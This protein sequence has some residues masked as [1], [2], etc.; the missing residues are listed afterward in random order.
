[1]S[2]AASMQT[3]IPAGRDEIL[4]RLWQVSLAD[5]FGFVLLLALLLASYAKFGRNGLDFFMDLWPSY[6]KTGAEFGP[7]GVKFYYFGDL[8]GWFAMGGLALVPATAVLIAL[9]LFRAR[10]PA[11]FL[12]LFPVAAAALPAMIGLTF[13]GWRNLFWDSSPYCLVLMLLGSLFGLAEATCRR[14][15]RTSFA[16]AI[17]CLAATFCAYCQL[18]AFRFWASP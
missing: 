17:L 7:T 1:M 10:R 11:R 8:P 4:P 3:K 2:S 12:G 6:A 18:V 5:L 13:L 14:L 9:Y 16:L 15:P